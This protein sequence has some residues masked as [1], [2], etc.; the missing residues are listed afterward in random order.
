MVLCT[1]TIIYAK[2]LK[3]NY[4]SIPTFGYLN[5]PILNITLIFFTYKITIGTYIIK[6]LELCNIV[7]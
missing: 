3:Y 2:N 1:Y 7:T 4:H 5:K 6:D